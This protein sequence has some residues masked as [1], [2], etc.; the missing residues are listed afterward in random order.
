MN[1]LLNLEY[2]Q[3]IVFLDELGI[4][5][6]SEKLGIDSRTVD[7][8][9]VALEVFL[10]CQLVSE[11]RTSL[12]DAG[13]TVAEYGKELLEANDKLILKIKAQFQAI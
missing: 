3:T 13:K 11:D 6:C 1:E 9:I 7:A 4:K 5:A 10:S 8:R 12:T 2:I